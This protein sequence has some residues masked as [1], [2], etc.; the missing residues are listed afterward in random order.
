MSRPIAA[1]I[2]QKALQNNLSIVRQMIGSARLW[3]VVKA[4][5][6]GHGIKKTWQSLHQADGFALLS[7]DEA[8]L[9][10]EGGWKKPILL[11]EGFFH[12]DDIT[13]LDQYNLTTIVHS[14][15]QIQAL[16]RAKLRAPLDVYLKMN[17]GMNRLGFQ[18]DDIYSTWQ[19]LKAIENVGTL[20]L[21]T[22]FA[23]AGY[24]QGVT[25]PMKK[26]SQAS[27]GLNC[28]MSL[29]N[30][31]AILRHPQTHLDWVRPG[32]ILYGASPDGHQKMIL[33]SGLEPVMTLASEIIAIQTIPLGSKIGYHNSYRANCEQRIG[34]IACGYADGYPRHAPSGTP[35]RVLEKIT[36]TIGTVSMDMM[37][38][39]LTTCPQ[40]SIGS[41]V[42]LWG[43]N[44]KI[45]DVATASKTVGYELMCA[46]SPRVPVKLE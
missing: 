23:E 41:K 45:D 28:Q 43:K 3:A 5:A 38:I 36:K 14:P 18:P 12:P 16:E 26:I 33:G 46:L 29:A 39:D 40:A 19:K 22:H 8:L 4:N 10:R 31:A 42:E 27:Q 6:Y 44:V 21:M 7:I 1:I 13:I 30:S 32:I 2:N 35:V 17:C 15:W 9:L 24:K 11:L 34:I 25:E 37:A 20:T